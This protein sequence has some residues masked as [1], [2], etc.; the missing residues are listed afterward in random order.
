MKMKKIEKLLKSGFLL[1]F[2]ITISN[3]YL[4][5]IFTVLK[6]SKYEVFFGR[7]FP[8]FRLNTGRY[9]PEK[10]QYLDTFQ[11]VIRK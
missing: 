10:T 1:Q 3:I 8:V 7:Y 4:T 6:V 5:N 2:S 9:G 11:T